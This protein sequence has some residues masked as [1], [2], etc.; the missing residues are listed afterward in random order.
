MRPV[1]I[2]GGSYYCRHYERAS[3]IQKARDHLHAFITFSPPNGPGVLIMLGSG[4]EFDVGFDAFQTWRPHDFTLDDFEPLRQHFEPKVPGTC[5]PLKDHRVQVNAE[6]QINLSPSVAKYFIVEIRIEPI[7]KTS[8]Q[9]QAPAEAVQSAT[10][11][12]KRSV[13]PL[14]TP[15]NSSNPARGKLSFTKRWIKKGL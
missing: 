6:P 7:H 2:D 12:Q 9:I 13:S 10:K 14:R 8:H 1:S 4:K 5:V 15:E 3:K 11:G